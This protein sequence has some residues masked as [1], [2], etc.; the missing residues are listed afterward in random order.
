MSDPSSHSSSAR[1]CLVELLAELAE[2]AV[3]ILCF[4]LLLGGFA[5]RSS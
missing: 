1:G 2:N 5:G 3:A 4:P